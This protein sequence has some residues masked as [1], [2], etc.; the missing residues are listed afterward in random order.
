MVIDFRKYSAV[1]PDL[2]INDVK[3]ERVTEYKD[4]GTVLD[5]KFNCNANSN[6]NTVT[7][8]VTVILSIL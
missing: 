3:V 7:L 6:T 4:L 5:S 8:T 2:F 1:V